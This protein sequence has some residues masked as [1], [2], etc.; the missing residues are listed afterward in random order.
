[1]D[2]KVNSITFLDREDSKT[3]AIATLTVN[4]E[5]AVHGIKVIEGKNGEFIQMPQKKIR[6]ENITILYSP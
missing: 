3:R 1:M 5:F 2:I 4:D 6:M